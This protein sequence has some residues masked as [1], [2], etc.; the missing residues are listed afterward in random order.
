MAL[1]SFSTEPVNSQTLLR[2][3]E[4]LG[5]LEQILVGVQTSAPKDTT[6]FDVCYLRLLLELGVGLGR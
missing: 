2:N 5:L 4:D 6:L 1:D 3:G